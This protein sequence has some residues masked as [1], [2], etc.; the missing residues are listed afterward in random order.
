MIFYL[1]PIFLVTFF[2]L[3][4]LTTAY[5]PSLRNIPG[6]FLA[7]FTNLW[8]MYY[9]WRGD[10]H[11][12]VRDWHRKYGD[13]IRIGPNAVLLSQRGQYEKVFGFK[14]DFIKVCPPHA[15]RT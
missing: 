7:K 4:T 2:L 6:P 14:E 9:V 15:P 3:Y 12:T 1:A 5:K 10:F 8:R 13:L 11:I